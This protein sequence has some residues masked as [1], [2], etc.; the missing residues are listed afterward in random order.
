[1]LELESLFSTFR[2]RRVR[3]NALHDY[4]YTG[5]RGRSNIRILTQSALPTENLPTG[6]RVY[7]ELETPRS[8]RAETRQQIPTAQHRT[9]CV[10]VALAIAESLNTAE[11][12]WLKQQHEFANVRINRTCEYRS[13]IVFLQAV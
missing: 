3:T 10:E 12:E 2:R 7:R 13:Y 8:K 6:V 4:V 1:M 5:R 9:E 11:P